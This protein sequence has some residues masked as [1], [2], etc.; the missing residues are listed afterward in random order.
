MRTGCQLVTLV[1]VTQAYMHLVLAKFHFIEKEM[2]FLVIFNEVMFMVLVYFHLL[3]SHLTALMTK[4]HL[5]LKYV[6]GNYYLGA[7][8]LMVAINI[9]YLAY[10]IVVY[11]IWLK[12]MREKII[13]RNKKFVTLKAQ[14]I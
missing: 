8:G 7:I 2:K 10:S 5:E 13:E 11:L 1:F 6:M 14:M 9:G 12:R 4:P 3:F